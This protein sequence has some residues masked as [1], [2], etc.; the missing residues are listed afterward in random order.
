MGTE[1]LKV[2]CD[3]HGR[4]A[5]RPHQRVLLRGLG[6]QIRTTHEVF[7][8]GPG[9]IDAARMSPLGELFR[10]GNLVNHTREQK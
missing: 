3:E 9:V 2:L 1:F 7:D 8:L 4:R 6:R 10:P 5:A